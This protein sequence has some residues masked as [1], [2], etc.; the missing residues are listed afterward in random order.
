MSQG[1]LTTVIETGNCVPS[2]GR[3]MLFLWLYSHD[4]TSLA[5]LYCGVLEPWAVAVVV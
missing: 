4:S 3:L 5:V 1:E 2:F